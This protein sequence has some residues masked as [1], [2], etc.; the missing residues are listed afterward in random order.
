MMRR[1]ICGAVLLSAVQA[2]SGECLT[3]VDQGFERLETDLGTTE[4]RWV[5]EIENRCDSGFDADLEVRF[6]DQ[7]GKRRYE[8]RDLLTVGPH[9]RERA[10]R[11][12]YMPA[13]EARDIE[14]VAVAIVAERERPF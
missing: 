12:F 1:A 2:A 8:V 4:V 9:G 7:E 5:A 3:V 11:P 13:V 14:T 6:L 10:G